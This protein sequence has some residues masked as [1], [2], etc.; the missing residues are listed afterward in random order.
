VPPSEPKR[1]ERSPNSWRCRRRPADACRAALSYREA[2]ARAAVASQPAPA[3]PARTA[4]TT[5]QARRSACRAWAATRAPPMPDTGLRLRARSVDLVLDLLSRQFAL[6]DKRLLVER[7]R[8]EL[9]VRDCRAIVLR[10]PEEVE[11][12]LP[13]T[14]DRG[15]RNLHDELRLA[16]QNRRDDHTWRERSVVRPLSDDTGPWAC[17]ARRPKDAEPGV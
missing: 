13:L 11:L 14:V 9:R 4:A 5:E 10:K 16:L 12:A 15:T 6:D 17:V 8:Q 7:V 1:A 2:R 3:V